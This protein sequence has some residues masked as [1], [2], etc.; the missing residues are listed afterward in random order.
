MLYY[1]PFQYTVLNEPTARQVDAR[2][3]VDLPQTTFV[4]AQRNLFVRDLVRFAYIR[5][6]YLQNNAYLQKPESILQKY[7]GKM[8]S[9][10]PLI[11]VVYQRVPNGNGW[12]EFIF[13]I[14]LDNGGTTTYLPFKQ[15][16]FTC[17]NEYEVYYEAFKSDLLVCGIPMQAPQYEEGNLVKVCYGPLYVLAIV[18]KDANGQLVAVP[19]GNKQGSIPINL[20]TN[21]C[22]HGFN[23]TTEIMQILGASQ[24]S[25]GYNLGGCWYELSLADAQQSECIVLHIIKRD[26]RFYLVIDQDAAPYYRLQE[27]KGFDDLQRLVKKVYGYFYKPSTKAQFEIETLI[28]KRH[29]EVLLLTELSDFIATFEPGD[30]VELIIE[31]VMKKYQLNYNEAEYYYNVSQIGR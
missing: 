22:I 29:S 12:H 6:C 8:P 28:R 3:I 19:I 18:A 23:L 1:I 5:H 11:R 24:Q 10:L 13:Y 14:H 2:L 16:E 30:D 27:F 25:A 4:E 26:Y 31:G 7:N 9:N 15:I 20:Q 17:R 21:S